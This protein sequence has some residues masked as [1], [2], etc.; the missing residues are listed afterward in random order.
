MFN[1]AFKIVVHDHN[2]KSLKNNI[3]TNKLN[4]IL[5]KF[6]NNDEFM[7]LPLGN[8]NDGPKLTEEI[9]QKINF[10]LNF[11]VILHI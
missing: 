1:T 9:E 10:S 5:N 3:N 4:Y 11:L 7:S 2:V 8:E 6:K